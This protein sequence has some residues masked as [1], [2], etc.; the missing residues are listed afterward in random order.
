MILIFALAS[1][2]T[3]AAVCATSCASDTVVSAMHSS[4]MS[5][6]KCHEDTQNKPSPHSDAGHKSCV[7]SAGCHFSQLTPI[8]SS[9]K[10]FFTDVNAISFPSFTTSGKSVDISPPLKPPA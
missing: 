5:G 7:M 10:L 8:E 3:L 1:G 9:A 2:P 4:E 6:M